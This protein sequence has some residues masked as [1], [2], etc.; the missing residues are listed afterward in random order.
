MTTAFGIKNSRAR[1]ILKVAAFVSLGVAA[2]IFL[3]YRRPGQPPELAKPPGVAEEGMVITGIH[4]S[5][6]RD[7]RTEWSLDAATGQYLLAERKILLHDLTVTFFTKTGSKVFLTAKRG[8]VMTDTHDMEAEEDVVARNDLY[9]LETEK[10][11]YQHESR[12]IEMDSPV[13]IAGQSGEISGDSLA[14]DLNRN[15]M[16]MKG[17][18][19]GTL[20]PVGAR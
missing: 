17:H 3:N 16:V 5:A 20:A 10:M 14:I 18:V 7:G 9:R 4:Q 12:L 8:M 11:R 13:K 19:Q 15:L 1:R 2:V 6:T